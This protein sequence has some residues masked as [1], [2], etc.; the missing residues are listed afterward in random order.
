MNNIFGQWIDSD[1]GT[2]AG[3][4]LGP[5]LFV[6]YTD[7]Q[8]QCIRRVI[9]A[10]AHTSSS[11][12][13]VVSG[14]YPVSIRK[15]ELCNREYI[16]IMSGGDNHP[17][18]NL[19]QSTTR[20]GLRFCPLKYIQIMSRE[21]E[22]SLGDSEICTNNSVT[23]A[24]IIKP[25]N[26][27]RVEITEIAEHITVTNNKE[28]A[29]N[30]DIDFINLVIENLSDSHILIFTDG[31]VYRGQV[32]FGASSAVLF[33]PKIDKEDLQIT[34]RAV[35]TEVSSYRCETEGILLGMEDVMQYLSHRKIQN[36]S[37]SIYVFS[38]CTYSIDTLTKQSQLNKHPK[39]LVKIRH[40]CKFLV[41]TSSIIKLVKIPGHKG[42]HGNE[43]ADQNAK[44]MAQTVA[45]QK[46]SVLDVISISDARRIA[47]EIAK[48]S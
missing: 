16:R 27:I 18:I 14:I 21:L 15:R 24:D 30:E 9:G 7:T 22:K 36:C 40:I 5:L 25:L 42:I 48:K 43:L 13:E 29:I 34:K 6:T 4:Q 10:K 1:I 39:I 31:L 33:P 3:T 11:A 38:D 8:L 32:G 20:D 45:N 28:D 47:S 19:W 35:G 44:Q 12:I 46:T 37:R 41:E 2:S 26:I 17:L 23:A